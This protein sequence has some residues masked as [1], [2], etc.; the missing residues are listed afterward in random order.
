M[1][2]SIKTWDQTY[3]RQRAERGIAV[4]AVSGRNSVSPLCRRD[5]NNWSSLRKILTVWEADPRRENISKK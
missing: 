2:Q 4:D 3:R 5:G 1:I